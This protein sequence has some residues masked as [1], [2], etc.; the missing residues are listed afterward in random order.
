[1]RTSHSLISNQNSNMKCL[2]MK[3]L[4][5]SFASIRRIPRK[6]PAVK[7]GG[8]LHANTRL[9]RKPFDEFCEGSTSIYPP[10][11][12]GYDLPCGTCRLFSNLFRIGIY[13]VASL[14][15]NHTVNSMRPPSSTNG[16]RSSKNGV[17][18]LERRQPFE[19]STGQRGR[20][21]FHQH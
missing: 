21:Y 5:R 10:L 7:F 15:F 6:R 20:H 13:Q 8:K 19:T 17:A 3:C 16:I 14:N 1:M 12:V 18:A 4:G 11:I 9:V 2:N